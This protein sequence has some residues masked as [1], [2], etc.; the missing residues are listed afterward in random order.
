MLPWLSVYLHLYFLLHIY[1][2]PCK[3]LAASHMLPSILQAV[4]DDLAAFLQHLPKILEM[5]K[6]G[7]PTDKWSGTF[8]FYCS[9]CIPRTQTALQIN[10]Q[11]W[12]FGIR[13]W[14][15][16]ALLFL[17]SSKRAPQMCV[18]ISI[19]CSLNLM[20]GEDREVHPQWGHPSH[21]RQ[22]NW[23]FMGPLAFRRLLRWQEIV[24]SQMY[25]NELGRKSTSP[26][27][28]N[29]LLHRGRRQA[30]Y[31]QVEKGNLHIN[32]NKIQ[33]VQLQ[34]KK[35]TKQKGMRE[36]IMKERKLSGNL[37]HQTNC[38]FEVTRG[39]WNIIKPWGI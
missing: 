34:R 27:F 36:I 6:K 37:I 2:F 14:N 26:V 35:E 12:G 3:F 19:R 28:W 16:V 32:R 29:M 23:S 4:N 24:Q 17:C 21:A 9:G 5:G 18:K 8:C 31:V 39:V 1:F 25:S 10:Q 20:T 30:F 38:A 11:K 7:S 15:T 22:L 33:C 13:A